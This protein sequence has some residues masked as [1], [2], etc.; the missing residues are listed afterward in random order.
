MDATDIKKLLVQSL[1]DEN[2]SRGERKV[3]KSLLLEAQPS[4]RLMAEIRG[5]AFDLARDRLE[6]RDTDR[7][8]GWLEDIVKVLYSKEMDQAGETMAEAVF[9][10]GDGI[11]RRLAG[12]F[13]G[14]A[15]TADVCVYTITDDRVSNAMIAAHRRGLA[16]RVIGDDDK[17]GDLGSDIRRLAEAGIPVRTDH[18]P[19]HMHH[20]FAVFD[21]RT[22]VTGS[23]NW[24][25]SAAS[26]NHENLVVTDDRRLVG[27]FG[28]EFER[29]WKE[30]G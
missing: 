10:P 30:F 8:I 22:I 27:S 9:S 2:L 19:N 26:D 3:L 1:D 4:A 7:V 23:Y 14:A 24:T 16:I 13:A 12:L 6:G 20:K 17:S 21:G 11:V 25:R 18:S 28:K 5:K 15:K 29:L